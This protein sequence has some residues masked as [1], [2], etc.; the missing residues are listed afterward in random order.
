[1]KKLIF[2]CAVML[3][4]SAASFAQATAP[5]TPTTSATPAVPAKGKMNQKGKEMSEKG[6][7]NGQKGKE[8]GE[9]GNAPKGMGMGLTPD[10][11]TKFKAFNE[12]HKEA[13]KKIQMDK[14][15][16]ADAKKTQIDA[17]KGT[18]EANVKT[19][20][21]ADQYTKWLAKRNDK[22]GD[23]QGKMDDHKGKKGDHEG[24]MEDHK[25]KMGE[26]KEMKNEKKGNRKADK[27]APQGAGKSN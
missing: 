25:D 9:K 20:L 23:H 16:S 5:A 19:V 1:M 18:Y 14:A 22:G 11:E 27:A 10:Q 4:L 24:K 8:M 2:A 17:L 13:V 15:L 21:N 12:S 26:K 7:E 6:K 3:T